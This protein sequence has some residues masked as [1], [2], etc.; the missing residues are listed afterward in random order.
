MICPTAQAERSAALRSRNDLEHATGFAIGCSIHGIA[1][2]APEDGR[3]ILFVAG[4]NLEGVALA[5][6]GIEVNGVVSEVARAGRGQ[7]H[8]SRRH[9]PCVSG[10]LVQTGDLAAVDRNIGRY[11]SPVK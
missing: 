9:T 5:G 2:K 10:T 4:R 1:D 7:S 8:R 6:L 11:E 3:S